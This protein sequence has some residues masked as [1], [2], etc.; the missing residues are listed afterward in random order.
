[1]ARNAPMESFFGTLKTEMVHHRKYLT[2]QEAMA[3]IRKY[4]EVFYNR[5]RRHASLGNLSPA[6]YWKAARGCLTHNMI[7]NLTS[8]DIERALAFWAD[9]KR[10]KREVGKHGTN[11]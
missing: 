11:S 2:R 9:Y 10:R 7:V 4:I 6:A 5:Q 8:K 1:M 3:D